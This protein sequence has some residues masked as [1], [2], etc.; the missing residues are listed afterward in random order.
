MRDSLSATSS[1]GTLPLVIPNP[2]PPASN[3]VCSTRITRKGSV[4]NSVGSIVHSAQ[5][6]PVLVALTNLATQTDLVREDIET[7]I[8]DGKEWTKDQREACRREDERWNEEKKALEGR[9]TDT[10]RNQ[11]V[12]LPGCVI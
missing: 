12:K 3:V 4:H 10:E 9:G 7:S 6:V 8:K 5:M 1:P 2:S 11:K